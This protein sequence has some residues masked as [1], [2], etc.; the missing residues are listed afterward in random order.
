MAA[1]PGMALV[2]SLCTAVGPGSAPLAQGWE[3]Q[4]GLTNVQVWGDT[5]DYFY[6][7]FMSGPPANGGYPGTLVIDLDTMT[8]T[9]FQAG[10]VESASAHVDAILSADHPCAD[11]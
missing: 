10:G 4:F 8:L 6:T 7:N 5:T 3:Q 11:Y 1:R 9:A 2:Q